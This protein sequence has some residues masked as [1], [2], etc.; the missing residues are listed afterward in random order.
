M[1]PE[2]QKPS[3]VLHLVRGNSTAGPKTRPVKAR[4]MRACV[5]FDTPYDNT[6]KAARAPGTGLGEAG[7]QV[8]CTNLMDVATDSLN[9]CDLI[10]VGGPTQYRT[11]PKETKEY[12]ESHAHANLSGKS[13]LAFDTRKDSV[14]A[15]SAA[16]Y[17]EDALRKLRMK[18]VG[19][20][21]S[22]I[23]VGQISDEDR[24]DLDKGQWKEWRHGNER[25]LEGE[26]AR[27][28]Q[29]GNQVGKAVMRP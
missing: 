11:A 19:Q 7:V 13:A 12:S 14:L 25:L 10:C 15:G 27:F 22:A 20:R 18:I 21:A 17:I 5:I 6:E 2:I 26:E 3:S 1:A 16:K 8:D 28:R 24:R 4:E 29:L 9:Q 23:M